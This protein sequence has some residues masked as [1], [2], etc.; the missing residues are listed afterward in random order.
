MIQ[1]LLSRSVNEMRVGTATRAYCDSIGR[2]EAL[3][4][5][6]RGRSPLASSLAGTQFQFN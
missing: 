3:V 5:S 6:N 4:R 2:G 1:L